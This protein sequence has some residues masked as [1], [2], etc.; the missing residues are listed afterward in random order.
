MTRPYAESCDQNKDVIH[1]V[2]QP[3]LKPGIEVLEIASGTA[4]H[5][6]Y[7]AG[8]NPQVQW[9]TSDRADYLP[10]IR[11]WISFANL[12]NLLNPIE[13]DVC[14]TW[15]D[16]QYDLVFT[17]NSLHIM[18]D[19]EAEA[20]IRGAAQRLKPFGFFISYGAF[21]YNG[22]FTSESNREFENWLKQNNPQSGIKHFEILNDIAMQSGLKLIDDVEMPANNR[23]LIWQSETLADN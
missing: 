10:G 8:L 2:I 7:F 4:Q 20:C 11:S 14:D 23:I 1:R 22:E 16:K 15:P 12:G 19:S 13:L 21:N 9:Q 5:A 3:Y 6:V 18:N 17:S